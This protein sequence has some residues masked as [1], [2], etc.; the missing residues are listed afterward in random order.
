[1]WDCVIN[2]EQGREVASGRVRLICMPA[3]ARLA[4]GDLVGPLQ[5]G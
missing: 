5:A 1:V 2:D 4:G 3:D